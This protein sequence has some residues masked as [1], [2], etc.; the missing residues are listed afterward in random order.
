MSLKEK[1]IQAIEHNSDHYIELTIHGR[2]IKPCARCLGKYIGMIAVL[3]LALLYF[4]GY[5]SVTFY[6]AFIAS[7]L[8]AIPAIID[9][10]TVKLGMRAGSNNAR[11]IT[12]FLLGAGISTYFLIMPASILFKVSTFFVYTAVFAFIK[13]HIVYDGFGNFIEHIKQSMPSYPLPKNTIYS[14]GVETGCCCSLC[15]GCYGTC[16]NACLCSLVTLV[17]IPFICCASKMI[18]GGKKNE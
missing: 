8:L 5:F 13:M 2:T 4:L 9:W 14:C 1:I 10:S 7:W 12:G 17:S 11:A 6:T 3:P 18:C 16:M 15:N